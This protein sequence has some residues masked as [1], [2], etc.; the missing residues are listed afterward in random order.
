MK[1]L[2]TLIL[3]VTFPWCYGQFRTSKWGMAEKEVVRS[4]EL[5]TPKSEDFWYSPLD[6]NINSLSQ[7]ITL[8]NSNREISYL[9]ENGR[10]TNGMYSFIPFDVKKEDSYLKLWEHTKINRINKYGDD[11]KMEGESLNWEFETPKIKAFHIQSGIEDIEFIY[12]IYD[13]S[14]LKQKDIL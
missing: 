4:E 2:L 8:N 1:P 6:L 3:C 12:V 7:T 10:F 5:V 9:F 13:S 11:F 14:K